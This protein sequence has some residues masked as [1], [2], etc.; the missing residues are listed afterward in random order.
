MRENMNGLPRQCLSKGTYL[1]LQ[2]GR[3]LRDRWQPERQVLLHPGVP[4]TTRGLRCDPCFS[5]PTSRL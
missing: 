2:S 4:F 1:S 3:T 5:K